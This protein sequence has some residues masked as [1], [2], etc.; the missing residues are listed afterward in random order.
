LKWGHNIKNHDK[1]SDQYDQHQQDYPDWVNGD[2][3]FGC[4]RR[5]NHEKNKSQAEHQC[6]QMHENEVAI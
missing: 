6:R 4:I 1:N 5:Y 2:Y 3:G